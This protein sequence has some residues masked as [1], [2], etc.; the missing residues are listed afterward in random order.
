MEGDNRHLKGNDN[1]VDG[2]SMLAKSRKRK[3]DQIYDG[4]FKQIIGD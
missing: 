3:I 1:G 4:R 2:S